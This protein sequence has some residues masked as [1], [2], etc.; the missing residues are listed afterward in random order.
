MALNE[1]FYHENIH[2]IHF[3][4]NRKPISIGM[5]KVTI[6]R[7]S[8]TVALEHP[9]T[10]LD[11]SGIAVG[12]AIDGAVNIL[13][14]HG[15][16]SA[17]INHSGDIYA[18]GAPL[19]EDSWTMGIT[20][21]MHS[22]EIITTVQIKNQALSTSGNYQ[23]FLIEDGHIVGHIL[24]PRTARPA[25]TLL[26]STVIADNAI[27]ADALSTGSFVLGGRESKAILQKT[28]NV[29][30]IGVVQKGDGEELLRF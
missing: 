10:R 7:R 18:L 25:S 22:E 13:K 16:V 17:L 15:I 9:K 24:D 30:F 27:E 2:T 21:P 8:S 5:D 23:N 6:N 19:A 14:A 4:H 11:F 26:S 3:P 12:Y 1:E 28:E 20:D 29:R